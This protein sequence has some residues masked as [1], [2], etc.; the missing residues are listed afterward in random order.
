MNS[1]NFCGIQIKM[2]EEP[3]SE[4]IEVGR[5]GART[6]AT[7]AL[8]QMMVMFL[9]WG[10]FA[11]LG[12]S[13][14]DIPVLTTNGITYIV[15]S[16]RSAAAI[17]PTFLFT[18]IGFSLLLFGY[19]FRVGRAIWRKKGRYLIPSLLVVLIIAVMIGTIGGWIL[20]GSNVVSSHLID[21]FVIVTFILPSF[22][23]AVLSGWITKKRLED[24]AFKAGIEWQNEEF[25][26]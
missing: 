19:G 6:F 3:I 2:A 11:M 16:G 18:G 12:S 14:I 21:F 5:I 1:V 8:V 4:R 25:L 7:G 22:L 9:F 13:A 17:L 10:S 26:D 24:F 20:R 15:I 23:M